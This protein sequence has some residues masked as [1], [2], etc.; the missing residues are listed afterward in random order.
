MRIL[1]LQ[2]CTTLPPSLGLQGSL[3]YNH[4]LQLAWY[5]IEIPNISEIKEFFEIT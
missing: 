5:Q 2:K 1:D 4:Q 3:A